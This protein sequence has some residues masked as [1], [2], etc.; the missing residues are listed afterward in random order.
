MCI[1]I[2]KPSKAALPSI[3]TLENCFDN[4]P[5]GAGFMYLDNGLIHIKKGYMTWKR[6][7]KAYSKMN[8]RD[9]DIIVYHFRIATAGKIDEHTCHP[10]PVSTS[11]EKLRATD[12]LTDYAV[13]HNGIIH[14]ETP[15]D[16]SDTQVFIKDILAP[17]QTSIFHEK[18]LMSLVQLSTKDSKLALWHI[19]HSVILTGKWIEDEGIYYSNTS[20]KESIFSQY[21]WLSDDYSFKHNK[22]GYDF[23]QHEDDDEF[24]FC[25][26]CGDLL[27]EDDLVC[28]DEY[29]CGTCNYVG[30]YKN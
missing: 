1:G 19:E 4:N 2:V 8:F 28:D 5:D 29:L 15:K 23:S 11:V 24:M 6:F 18:H 16:L 13:V 20:Y 22:K 12:I 30:R 10:F 21:Q 25:D 17:L 26:N 3:D 27:T 7:K 9:E 14:I